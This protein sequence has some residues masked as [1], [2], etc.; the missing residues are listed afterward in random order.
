MNYLSV[1][2]IEKVQELR[3]GFDTRIIYNLREHWNQQIK[4]IKFEK[5]KRTRV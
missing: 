5:D 3:P 2:E 4:R 1:N